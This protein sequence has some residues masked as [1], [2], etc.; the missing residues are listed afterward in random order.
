MDDRDDN[1]A[2]AWLLAVKEVS[3]AALVIFVIASVLAV[4]FPGGAP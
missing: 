3:G 2:S 1:G 4:A